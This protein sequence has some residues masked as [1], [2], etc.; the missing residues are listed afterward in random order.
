[1]KLLDCTLRDGGYINNWRFNKKF[2]MDYIKIMENME[3]D[4]VEIG[5]INK[6]VNYKNEIVGNVRNLSNDDIIMF[7]NKKF[8]TVVM[9]DYNNINLSL[10]KNKIGIDLVRI[11]FHK[12]DLIPALNTCLEV[13][14]LGYKVSV[15]AMAITNYNETELDELFD[16]INKHHLDILYIADSY[17]SLKQ[18]DIKHYS[19]LF[20]SKLNSA[21]IGFHLHNNMNNAYS[22]YEYLTNITNNVYIDS[23][24]FGM[25]RGAGNLQTELVLIETNRNF[26]YSKLI[27]LL[28]F[29]QQYIKPIF[30]INETSW[31][32]ELDYLLSGFLKMHP[33]YVSKMRDMNISMENRFFIIEKM[34]Q[35][36]IQFNYFDLI[37]INEIIEEFNEKI[38]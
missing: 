9:A 29:I 34:I 30:K 18:K 12:N 8:K 14:Q 38:L 19:E 16:F 24:L 5:F 17:G 3:I 36:K 2:L 23:T 28:Q 22:N 20:S 10:L 31:G 27:E 26:E 11:A 15:N 35:K 37:V 32:Y 21:S 6:K 7:Q 1:M 13:K 4:F 33:N 25:G